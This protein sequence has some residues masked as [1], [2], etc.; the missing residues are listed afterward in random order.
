MFAAVIE[1]QT[2]AGDEIDDRTGDE[3]LLRPGRRKNLSGADESQKEPIES[4]RPMANNRSIGPS[5]IT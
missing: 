3:D 1:L 2:G 4:G 5:P